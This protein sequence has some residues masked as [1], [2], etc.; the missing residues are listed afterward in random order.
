M[1][2]LEKYDAIYNS[3]WLQTVFNVIKFYLTKL[4]NNLLWILNNVFILNPT[5]CHSITP[6]TQNGRDWVDSLLGELSFK[7]ITITLP[8]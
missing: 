4:F 8:I 3:K 5:I 6:M 1:I 7:Q 2:R